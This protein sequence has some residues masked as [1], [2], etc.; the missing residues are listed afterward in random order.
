MGQG[1]SQRSATHRRDERELRRRAIDGLAAEVAAFGSGAPDSRVI[2][3]PGLVA[4]I[5]PACPDRSLFNSVFFDDGIALAHA[6]DALASEYERAGVRAW[7]VWVPDDDRRTAALLAD[8]GHVLDSA[9]RVMAL[10]L[11]DLPSAPPAPT[12][13]IEADADPPA[14]ARI[15][16]RAYGYDAGSFAAALSG[17]SDPPLHWAFAAHGGEPVACV[18]S[19]DVGDDCCVTGVAT[20]PDHRRKGIA[21]WLLGRVLARARDRGMRSASLQAAK[22]GAGVYERLGFQDLGSVQLWELRDE[23]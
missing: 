21:G 7:A 17:P 22:A 14:A 13:V 16:D 12:G 8:R 2:R 3:L 15:N 20:L 1:F 19:I 23:G 6:L 9:P 10:W 11:D 4:A 5:A 18:A